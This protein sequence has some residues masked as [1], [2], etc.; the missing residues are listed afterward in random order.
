[1]ASRRDTDSWLRETCSDCDYIFY[2]LVGKVSKPVIED[3][4]ILLTDTHWSKSPINETN[5]YRG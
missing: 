4:I 1:M 2:D 5:E 3:Y